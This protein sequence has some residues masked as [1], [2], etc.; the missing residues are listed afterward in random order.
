MVLSTVVI[1]GESRLVTEAREIS[2]SSDKASRTDTAEGIQKMREFISK[3]GT[4]PKDYRRT[5]RA[6]AQLENEK[7]EI[8][9]AKAAESERKDDGVSATLTIRK[10]QI[11]FEPSP[12]QVQAGI[13][14]SAVPWGKTLSD[15][16]TFGLKDGAWY[17]SKFNANPVALGQ[18]RF[19]EQIES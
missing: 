16:V 18:A 1:S 17:I 11:L 4:P 14:I 6:L 5:S 9:R 2:P 15:P 13:N 19:N 8:E 3:R 12:E 7:A 10:V